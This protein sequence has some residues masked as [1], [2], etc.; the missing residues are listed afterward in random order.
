MYA[1]EIDRLT[2]ADP[3]ASLSD[4]LVGESKIWT[5]ES[6][7]TVGDY[8]R[9]IVVLEAAERDR[10]AKFCK[11]A[12]DAGLAERMVRVAERQAETVAAAVREA[13]ADSGLSEDVR[14]MVTANVG[15]HLRALAG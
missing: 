15:R 2:T 9:G 14:R 1:D 3:D 6:V 7:Q 11:L 8:V 5:G 13:L 4:V 10:C 12:I